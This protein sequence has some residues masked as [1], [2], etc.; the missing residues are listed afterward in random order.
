MIN[1]TRRTLL[2]LGASTVGL[3]V[4]GCIG[5]GSDPPSS[6]LD[7]N[8]AADTA[9]QY[10]GPTCACCDEYQPYLEDHL[11]ADL[12]VEVLDDQPALL[13]RKA[14]LGVPSTLRSCHTLVL[15]GSVFEGH[16]PVE[17]IQEYLETETDSVGIALP[18]MPAG[19]PGMGGSKD[20]TWTIYEFYADGETD[21]FDEI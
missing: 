17:P 2:A 1:T 12:A 18:G 21:V 9:T 19:S 8:L 5:D 4:A 6:D 3:G 14:D 10:Q 13:E 11:D 16:L 15:D 7:G 20:E